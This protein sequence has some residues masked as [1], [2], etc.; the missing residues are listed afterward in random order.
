MAGWG[1]AVMRADVRGR[2]AGAASAAMLL[3]AACTHDPYVSV[4]TANTTPVGEWRIERQVDRVTGAPISSALL[5]TRRVSNSNVM[6]APPAQM[7]L[8]CFKKTR[9]ERRLCRA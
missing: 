9:W 6:F 1:V 7:P 2:M 3:L 5:M 8:A 4:T